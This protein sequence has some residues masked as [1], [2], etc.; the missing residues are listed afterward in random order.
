MMKHE[1]QVSKNNSRAKKILFPT[2][3][4]VL[5]V[6]A[7]AFIINLPQKIQYDYIKSLPENSQYAVS[8]GN[9]I[10]ASSIEEI[11]EY[12]QS[13]ERINSQSNTVVISNDMKK[14]ILK[15]SQTA[16]RQFQLANNGAMN[17]YMDLINETS[18]KL[19]AYTESSVY[20]GA[21]EISAD[22]ITTDCYDKDNNISTVFFYQVNIT[23]FYPEWEQYC[24]YFS[25]DLENIFAFYYV[26]GYTPENI[27][28]N[29]TD[30]FGWYEYSA[31]GNYLK[32]NELFAS[33]LTKNSTESDGGYIP[34]TVSE[35]Y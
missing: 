29:Y 21:I 31:D 4:A 24:F 33:Y 3:L 6:C 35:Y 7:T 27:F 12:L 18:N 5:L 15:K 20:Y 17:T 8:V 13:F 16:F 25:P 1:K 19:S 30:E 32:I 10:E 34:K 23:V 2:V 26:N 9:E 11:N 14:E 22:I 28:A